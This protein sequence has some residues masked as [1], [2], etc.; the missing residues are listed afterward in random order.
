MGYASIKQTVVIASGAST[1]SAITLDRF[2]PN[3]LI[4]V[5]TMS[6]GMAVDVQSSPDNGTTWYQLYHSPINSATVGC[7][8]MR[9]SAVVGSGAGVFN[10]NYGVGGSTAYPAQLRFVATGVISGGASFT[11]LFSD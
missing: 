3:A 4:Y 2:Y 1:S 10:L 8:P 5:G 11:A 9:I 7:N 6:T